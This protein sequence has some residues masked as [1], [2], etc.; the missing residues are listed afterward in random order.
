MGM[1]QHSILFNILF[2][3]C[4]GYRGKKQIYMTW[5]LKSKFFSLFKAIG[6]IYL[7]FQPYFSLYMYVYVCIHMYYVIYMIFIYY[8]SSLLYI[9]IISK[10]NT[11]THTHNKMLTESKCG[12]LLHTFMFSTCW[13]FFVQICFPFLLI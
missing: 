8:A 12:L 4:H 11:Y 2:Y 9:L 1:L 13:G 10:Y 7:L 3:L 6:G 5:R